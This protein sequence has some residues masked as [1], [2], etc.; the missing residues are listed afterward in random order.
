MGRA[1]EILD[2]T[3]EWSSRAAIVSGGAALVTSETVVG[4]VAFGTVATGAEFISLS[5]SVMSAGTKYL[6]N[7]YRGMAAT[8]LSTG[9]GLIVPRGLQQV[10]PA[11]SG[12]G[13]E[14]RKQFGEWLAGAEGD[15]VGQAAGA[16][17]CP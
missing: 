16:I 3:S 5:T 8:L 9:V 13:G 1:A 12:F 7:N 17:I 11:S 15:L 14:F 6:D 4:G 2:K 10:A